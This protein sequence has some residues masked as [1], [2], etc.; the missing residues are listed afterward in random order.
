MRPEEKASDVKAVS[1]PADER[2]QAEAKKFA[3][4]KIK[5]AIELFNKKEYSQAL[6]AYLSAYR[7]HPSYGAR[8]GAGT[9]LVKLQRFDEAQEAYEL[10]LRDFGATMPET[11]KKRALEQ[12]DVMRTVTGS[13]MVT[14][15]EI[16]ALIVVD[17]RVRGEHPLPTAMSVL[18][19]SRLVRVYR[20][21]YELFEA[22]I[23]VKKGEGQTL[24]VKMKPLAQART[25]W[26]RVGE[27]SGRRME[28]VVDGVPVG[29]TPWEG[30]VSTGEHS[31]VLRVPATTPQKS[32]VCGDPI[33][34]TPPFELDSNE[35]ELASAPK[36]VVV[37]PQEATPVQLK[38]EVRS[39]TVKIV[40]SAADADVY[41]DGVK[42]SRGGFDGKLPPGEH[43][44]KIVGN[45]Y[46]ERVEK[47]RVS[48]GEDTAIQLNVK[49]DYSAPRWVPPSH[50]IVE[51]G[52][53][54]PIA[55]SLGGELAASCT[56]KCVQGLA[57]GGRAML[58]A[59]YELG[60]GLGFGLTGGYFG[61]QQSVDQRETTLTR[62][63][64]TVVNGIVNDTLSMRNVLLG[65]YGSYR[66]GEKVPLRLGVSA[67]VGFGSVSSLR[68]GLFED[69]AVGPLTQ[70]GT[71]AWVFVEPELRI[72]VRV[73]EH[74]GLGLSVSGLMLLSPKVPQWNGE[75]RLDAHNDKDL[76]YFKA[77]TVVGS[78]IFALTEGVHVT[79]AF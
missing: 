75:M 7:I 71:F 78:T 39:A 33:L 12:I 58:R 54:A 63:N 10:A 3:K 42:I 64:G 36:M 74:F 44:V 6:A 25:G 38:A 22:A 29:M 28:V 8:V 73:S 19:G 49:K 14:D 70:S 59:G 9:C 66:L 21:G 68:T 15:A 52:G 60:R 24:A 32:G 69:L 56:E 5:K 76:A 34:E 31:V 67:G 4:E 16:G 23:D 37:K 13:L 61:I 77:E 11:P 2:K 47:I 20:E 65:A 53:S 40:P 26:L 1:P 57:I 18:E 50:F 30:P 72:G 27:T 62:T 79:Y 51:L 35:W 46:V 45:G 48:D 43:E 41:V 17:G 55:P